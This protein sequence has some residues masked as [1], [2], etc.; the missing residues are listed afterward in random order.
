MSNDLK[1]QPGHGQRPNAGR[2]QKGKSGN[3]RGRPRK[4]I[5]EVKSDCRAH[6]PIE[7]ALRAE[8]ER[9]IVVTDSSGRHEITAREAMARAIMANGI[10]GGPMAQKTAFGLLREIEK[11][12]AD[13][14]KVA[15]ERWVEYKTREQRR[16]KEAEL[17]GQEIPDP[18]P[19]PDNIHLDWDRQEVKFRGPVDEECRAGFQRVKERCD[20]VWELAFYYGELDNLPASSESDGGF[21]PY[22]YYWI[23][24]IQDLP[25]RIRSYDPPLS[26]VQAMERQ[27]N[28][29]AWE[30][31][32][33]ARCDAYDLFFFRC[34]REFRMPTISYKAFRDALLTG[35]ELRLHFG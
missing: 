17:A 30:A 19:H 33:Q 7:R 1:N 26:V 20:L 25:P 27:Q 18:L 2:F 35:R 15:F 31:D 32:L 23:I 21:G 14:R 24:M 16:I 10:K 6:L 28:R 3:P 4:E 13:A 22:S 9:T 11:I 5:G 29:R 34:D 8:A 12:E